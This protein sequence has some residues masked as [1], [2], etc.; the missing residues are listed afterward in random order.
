[1]TRRWSAKKNAKRGSVTLLA[2][3]TED[4]VPLTRRR[5]RSSTKPATPAVTRSATRRL[6]TKM[7]TSS[8]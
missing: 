4:F 7:R 6:R 5:R 2:G 3:R 8:P 1:M